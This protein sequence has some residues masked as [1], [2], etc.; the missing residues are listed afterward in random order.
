VERY[1]LRHIAILTGVGFTRGSRSCEITTVLTTTVT[2]VAPSG[3]SATAP[4]STYRAWSQLL[5]A[6]DSV[7]L[8]L[9]T[10]NAV[11]PK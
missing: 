5:P 7:E 10:L 6:P 2:T 8:E 11:I 9:A 3:T 1:R 4:E